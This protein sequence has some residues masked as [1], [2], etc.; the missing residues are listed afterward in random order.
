MNDAGNSTVSRAVHNNEDEAQKFKKII[1]F[2]M[3]SKM[4]VVEVY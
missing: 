4:V 1:F 3:I 2:L